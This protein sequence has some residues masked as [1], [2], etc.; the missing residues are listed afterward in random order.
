MGELQP[1]WSFVGIDT[2]ESM[3]A[4]TTRLIG[5]RGW[6]NRVSLVHGSLESLSCNQ[7]FNGA[8]CILVS[9]FMEGDHAKT[10]IFRQIGER[11][12]KGRRGFGI[13]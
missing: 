9:H 4:Q 8:T 1:R 5:S 2:S 3:I 6:E 7:Q 11:L 13:F 10:S 12:T